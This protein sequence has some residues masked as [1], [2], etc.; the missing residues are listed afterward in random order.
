MFPGF[1]RFYILLFMFY[2]YPFKKTADI[3]VV[4]TTIQ[5][6]HPYDFVSKAELQGTRISVRNIPGNTGRNKTGLS[7]QFSLAI[8]VIFFKMHKKTDNAVI[9]TITE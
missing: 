5:L 3:P 4:S 9:F 7:L 8:P 1:C 6:M 2:V